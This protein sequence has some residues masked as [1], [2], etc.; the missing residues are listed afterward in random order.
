MRFL[1][2]IGSADV[3]SYSTQWFFGILSVVACFFVKN[4]RRH[5]VLTSFHGDGY[6]GNT[7]VIF[8]HLHNSKDLQAVWLSRNKS[9]VRMLKNKFG[10]NSAFLIHSFKG[11]MLLCRA[12]IICFTHGT[13]DYPFM[14]L[15]RNSLLIH[16]YHGL[17]TKRGEFMKP[18]GSTKINF[19][20]KLIL[21]YRFSQI[22]YFLS[23]SQFVTDIF[24]ERFGLDKDQ[25]LKTGFPAYDHLIHTGKLSTN[26]E[27]DEKLILY[28]PTYRRTTKTKW[29]PF[30][31][32]DLDEL[33]IFLEENNARIGL[34]PHP[35]ESTGFNTLL[36]KGER[37][38]LADDTIFEDINT[39]TLASDAIVTDYSGIYLEGLLKDIPPLFIP[40]DY[41]SYERGCP[42]N[43]H[44]VTP[45][46]KISSQK[47][48]MKGLKDALSG[49]DSFSK[50]RQRVKNLFFYHTDGRST[51]R[52]SALLKKHL[53]EEQSINQVADLASS[54]I[55]TGA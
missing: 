7:K 36:S 27:K 34:R 52:V 28:A 43:Y 21:N 49:A 15:N 3:V 4:T 29:F 6:R 22:D 32:F 55:S 9:V 51:E 5:I 12:R 25:F 46:P 19:F 44:D 1:K 50:E 20:H 37:I 18:S 48:F 10:D 31:D 11:V 40:Y 26:S 39:L 16:T 33:Y 47:D 54:E 17:P 45:G 2:N 14:R 53:V 38:F 8:E 41:E 24:K 42:Y 35:N 30:Q 23:S 13:S